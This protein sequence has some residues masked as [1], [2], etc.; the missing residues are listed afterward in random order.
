MVDRTPTVTLRTVDDDNVR[1]VIDLSVSQEQKAFVASNVFSLAQ[2]FAASNVWVR[3]V[4]AGETAVGFVMLAD[5]SG[6]ERYYL[7]RFMIDEKYQHM[8]FGTQAMSLMHE[9]VATRPGGTRVYLS[10]VPAEG[11]PGPF[12][13]SL[14]YVETGLMKDGEVE[15]AL[16]LRP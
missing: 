5:N 13:R 8:G 9:Y 15:A 1:A 4:Y 10:F 16:D 12:Y 11:G 2:A 6:T 14:G 3:A 7:W